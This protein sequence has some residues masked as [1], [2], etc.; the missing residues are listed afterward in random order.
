MSLQT[1]E[2][3]L[4]PLCR[5]NNNCCNSQ[6]KSLGVCWCSEE[7]FPNEIFDLVPAEEIRKTCICKNCLKEFLESS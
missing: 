6:D 4:C 7:A 5:Q 2:I 3:E 1:N